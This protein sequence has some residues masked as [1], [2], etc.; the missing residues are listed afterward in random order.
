MTFFGIKSAALKRREAQTGLAEGEYSTTLGREEGEGGER[1][2]TPL[3]DKK[4]FGGEDGE[5]T[6]ERYAIPELRD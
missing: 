3:E 1:V 4:G 5:R 2:E 6:M